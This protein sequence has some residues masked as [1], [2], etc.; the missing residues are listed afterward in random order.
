MLDVILSVAILIRLF[1]QQIFIHG[2]MLGV[3]GAFYSV[4]S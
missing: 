3:D 4:L 2:L 1:I